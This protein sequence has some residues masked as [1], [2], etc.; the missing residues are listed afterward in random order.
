M[1]ISQ[2]CLVLIKKWGGFRAKAY[3][4]PVRIPNSRNRTQAILLARQSNER[5]RVST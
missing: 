5:K 2:N 4:D 3:L 1:N